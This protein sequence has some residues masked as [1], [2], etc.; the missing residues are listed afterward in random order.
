MNSKPPKYAL[1]FLEWYCPSS[2]HEGIEGDLIEQFD[3]DL[4]IVSERK[5]RIKFVFNV[6][7]FF[8]PSI[9]FRNK[10]SN[11]F[12]HSYMLSNYFKIAF[13]SL[14]RSKA[15]SFIN[16]FGLALGIACCVLIA[17]FVRD[18]MT[19]DAFH[20]KA[21]RIYRVY[22]KEDWGDKQ[23]FFYTSTPFPMGPTLKEN[24]AEVEREVRIN[25]VSS[26]VKVGQRQF[27]ETVV[28]GGRDLF[29]VFDFKTING[30]GDVAL[31]GQ[32]NVVITERMAKKYFGTGNPI[33]KIISLQLGETFEDFS[34]K[35]VAKN[36]PTNSSIQFDILISDLNLPKLYNANLLTS[37]WFNI[38][39]ET[40]VLLR[41]GASSKEVENKFPG[42]FKTII[43][44]EKFNESKYA[45]GLQPLTDIHLNTDFPVGIAPV[46]NAKYS[47]VLTAIALLILFVA[48]INFVTLSVGRS[49]LRAKE[50]GIRKVVGAIRT[51]LITQFVGEAIIVTFIALVVGVALSFLNL[52]LF[53]DLSGKQLLFPFNSFLLVVVGLLLMII[54]LIS[55]SYPAFVLSSFKPIA[56][57]KGSAQS[58]SSKQ[59]VRKI[60]V[61]VQL[62]L[63]IFLISST[64]LMREQLSFLQNKD[65]G[66]DKE[67]LAVV[68]LNAP[69]TGRLRQKIESGFEIAE[70]FKTELA[71]FPGIVSMCGSSH[72]FGNGGWMSLGY[73]D[74]KKVYRTFNMNVVDDDYIPTLKMQLVNGRNFS[75]ANPSDKRRAV[76][77]NE[78]FVKEYG[79][80]DAIGKKIPGK[81]FQDHEII[82]VVKDFNYASLYTKVQPMVLVE[83]P[84]IAFSGIQNMNVDAPAIPKLLLRL[85]PENISSTIEQVRA[86]WNK[87][88]GEEEFTFSFV[89]QAM[90]RQYRSDQNLGKIVGV[91][92]LLAILIGS[93]GLYAL[94]SLAMQNRTKEISIRKVMGANDN[95][96]LI[97]L[98]KEYVI[99][100]AGSLLLSVP[101]T[102]YLMNNWLSTFEYKV[103]I[104]ANV[105]ILAGAISLFIALATISF[106]TLKTVW[107]NPAKSLKYE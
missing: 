23:Q 52:P 6:I 31:T 25:N 58:A 104:S 47:Y 14:W 68:Q 49:M 45:P 85:N 30:N 69:R 102:W 46:S 27:N 35:A 39:P 51:Q 75:D 106:Q 90:E 33:D 88:S 86:V 99:L 12:I 13:R 87:I 53:N 97:L 96:L 4:E 74:E 28:I 10:F 80:T 100:V 24:L 18:E 67:Q 63:S 11:S 29:K 48:C 61:G 40:Y 20:S 59:S 16:V 8:R 19:Y 9:L 56:I 2:L 65:L 93:L 55:G 17:L 3:C 73:T 50:V 98:S 105:F 77:V 101:F 84:A 57:L 64:L 89:D 1:R 78:A 92:T 62:V 37:S 70:R 76:I 44:E 103:G 94:A 66:F 79:W 60:L 26:Q 38:V 15:H 41:E 72:D 7:K 83:D 43:G 34:V 71:K 81:E 32:S 36:P 21:N 22:A 5:A 82:G 107:T 95:S 54:G 42:I 91:A